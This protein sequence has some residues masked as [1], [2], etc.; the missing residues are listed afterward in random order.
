MKFSF[1]HLCFFK[2]YIQREI[3]NKKLFF[4][5]LPG[6]EKI[7]TRSISSSLGRYLLCLTGA[8]DYVTT[9]WNKRNYGRPI[10][11]TI[12]YGLVVKQTKFKFYIRQSF[13]GLDMDSINNDKPKYSLLPVVFNILKKLHCLC[14]FLYA[15]LFCLRP[16]TS[17]I[18]AKC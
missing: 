12:L 11:M 15:C 9:E 3:L 8:Y 4:R 18:L 14:L 5:T 16:L 7:E 10:N 2:V 17:V 1:Y 6:S 13:L